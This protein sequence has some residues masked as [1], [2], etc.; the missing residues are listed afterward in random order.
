M[1]KAVATTEFTA[2]PDL[3]LLRGEIAARQISKR[4]IAALLGYSDSLFSLFIN[5]KREAPTGFEVHVH[6]ALDLLERAKQAGAEARE[7]VLAEAEG[8]E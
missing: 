6:E 5:G 1:S 7:R 8:S 4:D 2:Q 3:A